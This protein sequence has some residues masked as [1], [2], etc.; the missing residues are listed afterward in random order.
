MQDFK[1]LLE[2]GLKFHGHKCP[3]MPLGL[4]AGLAALEA[5]GVQ[6]AADGQLT[7]LVE[8]DRNHC[9]AC[10]V[11]GVQVATGSTAGKGNLKS[12]GYGK[13]A[14]TLIDNKTGRSVRV[15]ATREAIRRNQESELN[16]LRKQ[17]IPASQVEAILVDPLIEVV[18]AESV[19]VLFKIEPIQRVTLPPMQPTAFDAVICAECG[20]VTVERYARVKRGQIVC[21]PCAEKA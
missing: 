7:A 3:A 10:F 12:L 14:L 4:R 18:L 20:E 5:L 1:E 2:M 11:D 15:A 16:R 8:T 17:G 21:I 19:D 9:S 13:F 6:R